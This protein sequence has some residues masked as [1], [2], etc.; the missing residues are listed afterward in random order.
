MSGAGRAAVIVVGVGLSSSATAAEVRATVALALAEHERTLADVAAI[1]TRTRFLDD[2]RLRLGPP[3]VG[4]DDDALVAASAPT[5]R[6]RGIAAR[7][8]ETA[9]LL[10]ARRG[11]AAGELLGPSR[12][13]AHVVA[14]VASCDVAPGPRQARP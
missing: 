10:A 3:L 1:A 5:T 14:A 2:P 4:V 11:D 7:V 6:P 9:A 12:R 13:S 8:A